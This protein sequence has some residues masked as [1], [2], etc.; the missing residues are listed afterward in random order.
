MIDS[1]KQTRDSDKQ[2]RDSNK[3]TTHSC[4]ERQMIDSYWNR[5]TTLTNKQN[6]DTV[7]HYLNL[8]CLCVCVTE[9]TEKMGMCRE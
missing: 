6:S 1:D 7:K 3:Q 5:R 9:K 4:R 2:T 8:L